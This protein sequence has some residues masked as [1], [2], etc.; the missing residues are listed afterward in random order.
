MDQGYL[1]K[2]SPRWSQTT[3]TIVAIVLAALVLL[4]IYRF[5]YLIGPVLIALLFS[6]L[7]HP[8]MSLISRRLHLPWKLTVTLLYLIFVAALIALI[9]WGGITMVNEIQNLIKF[10]NNLVVNLPQI[11]TDFL[12]KPLVIG[13]FSIDLPNLDLTPVW[14]WLQGM[15][16]PAVTQAANLIG[17]IASGAASVVT[18]VGF[19][20]LISY[21]ISAETNENGRK[22]IS[23]TIPGYQ[24]DIDRMG[25]QMGR[26]WNS[27][28]R[29]QLI[30]VSVTIVWYSIMLGSMGVS[31]FFGLAILAGLARFVPYVG[32]FVAWLTYFLVGLFQPANMFGLQPFWFGIL[33]VGVALVSDF[34]IDN[35]VSPRVMSNALKVHPA[36]VLVTVLVAANLFGVIGMLLAAPV[37][38]SVKLILTYVMRKLFDKD[39]WMGLQTYPKPIPL[40]EELKERWQ[41]IKAGMERLFKWVKS[42]YDGIRTKWMARHS[43]NSNPTKEESQNE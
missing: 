21:F 14:T 37:L 6:Y 1:G 17:S 27:F 39:P 40:R 19:T 25:S 3:K 30:V 31:F 43:K 33:L 12:S 4:L 9:T 13:S 18:W 29:G 36:A 15:I 7:I 35:F 32:P 2:S 26:I 38:A 41:K 23:I 22:L 10:I 16:Q 5:K 24:G 20:I 11:V 42:L 28:L 8:L 34:I